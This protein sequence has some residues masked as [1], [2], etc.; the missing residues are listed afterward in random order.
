VLVASAATTVVGAPVPV[1][2]AY[3]TPNVELTGHGFGHGRGMGQYGALGYA[4]NHGWNHQQILGHYY[5]NT[6]AGN[7][8]NPEITVI[9]RA[10]DDVDTLVT[11]ERGRM[12]TNAADGTFPALR[13]VMTGPDTFRVD[14]S[15]S[16]GGP[17]T[18]IR[19]GMQGP[20]VFA[21][22]NRNDDR[23]DMLQACEPNGNRRW[24]RGELRAVEGLDGTSRTVNVLEMQNY[25]KGTVPRESPASWGDL[26]GGAGMHALRAQAVAARSYAQASNLAHYAKTCDTI[27]C[28]VYGG[29]AVQSG[30]SFFDLEDGRSD[31]AVNETAGEVRLLNGAPAR[32][33]YSSSTGG[34]TAGGAFPAVPD[35]GDS[36]ASNPNHTWQRS[37]PVSTVQGAYPQVG[38]L[39][40]VNVTRRNGLGDFGGRVLEVQ[41]VGSNGTVITSGQGFQF[42][43]GLL[44]DW[45][46]VAVPGGYWVAAADGSIFPFGDAPFLGSMGG[47]PL[48]RPMVGVASTRS[49]RGYWMVAS[50]GGIFTFGDA[51]FYGS[52]GGQPLAQ[53]MVGMAPT[54]SGNGYWTVASDGGIFTFGDAPFLGSMGGQPLARPLNG[55]AP[56]AGGRGYW[57]VAS[58]GGI[59]TFGDAV[60]RGSMGGQPLVSPVVGMAATPSGQGYWLVAADGGIFTF[61]DAGFYGSIGGAPLAQPVTGMAVTPTGRGYWLVAQDGGIFTFGDAEFFGS[62]PGLGTSNRSTKIGMAVPT[63]R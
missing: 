31:R 61:G 12:V 23:E 33:E 40:A 35:E 51:G 16:C 11:Q 17:W 15:S 2:A 26:G 52:K 60:F 58:D 21:P 37:V 34:Y 6:A 55:M 32:T 45:F 25:L 42:A 5:A 30:S 48:L 43:L 10:F 8:G 41:V 22:Q 14:S 36:I 50:D 53:P 63:R 19:S 62:V 20:V 24:Y 59:F 1:A 27:E 28:Q 54:P 4:L 56:T 18:T 29:R 9:L 39:Q 13:A 44:S 49:G 47:Q 46:R 57:L 3:P 38:T 7:I